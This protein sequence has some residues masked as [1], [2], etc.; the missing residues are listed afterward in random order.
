[1]KL[2]TGRLSPALERGFSYVDVMIAVAV[3]LIGVMALTGALT[4]AIVRSVES[5]R[6][7]IA[8]QY[9]SSTIEAIFSARDMTSLGW[10]S[11]QN[12]VNGGIFLSGEQPI[13]PL[14]GPDNVIG[15]HDD[16]GEPVAGFTRRIEIEDYRT[17]NENADLPPSLRRIT[18]TIFYRVGPAPRDVS[19]S[20]T[21]GTYRQLL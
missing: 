20:T 1:M 21:I 12:E 7:L 13:R 5:E 18:V 19:V 9:A 14:P 6:Q 8:K 2:R 3:L 4:A 15:T 16:V 11:T 17:P 10:A